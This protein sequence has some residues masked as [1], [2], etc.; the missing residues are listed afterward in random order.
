MP[1]NRKVTHM[2]S[3]VACLAAIALI[4]APLGS[5][6][7]QLRWASTQAFSQPR[8]AQPSQ[9]IDI[10]TP[11]V[12]AQESQP[13]MQGDL[14]SRG[15]ALWKQS[16]QFPTQTL[17]GFGGQSYATG[18]P[19]GSP[20]MSYRPAYGAANGSLTRGQSNGSPIK[21]FGIL[22]GAPMSMTSIT[23]GTYHSVQLKSDGTVWTWGY[24]YY[25]ALGYPGTERHSGCWSRSDPWL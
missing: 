9:S 2:Y 18:L 6:P 4:V 8:T 3:S 13:L 15:S 10:S 23:G 7:L 17:G 25:G 14:S 12:G 24:N 20:S 1:V 21:A 11:P 16:Q 5:I 19:L 22:M